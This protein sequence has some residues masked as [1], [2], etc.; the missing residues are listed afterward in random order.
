ML[1]Q[2]L[3]NIPSSCAGF[4]VPR[5]DRFQGE[6]I[7][8][9]EERLAH[10]TGFTG[11]AGL[12]IVTHDTP[13]LFVDGRYTLQ[14]L[15]QVKGM[16][17]QPLMQ[18]DI[19]S[20]LEKLGQPVGF[21]PWLTTVGTYQKWQ[22]YLLP[23]NNNP[24]DSIWKRDKNPTWQIE[25]Y[26]LKY[27]GAS[28]QEKLEK[29]FPNKNDAYLICD[30]ATLSWLCNIRGHVVPFTPFVLGW[31]VVWQGQ[32]HVF[33][34]GVYNGDSVNIR[35]E[36]ECVD[37]LKSIS[38]DATIFYDPGQTPYAFIMESPHTKPLK[39]PFMLA[40]ACKNKTEQEL[41]NS[42]H[43]KDSVAVVEFLSCLND[44]L[45][46]QQVI[47]EKQAATMLLEERKKQKDFCYPSFETIS[48]A[49]KNGA[50]IHY[51]P[52][53]DVP[54]HGLYLVDSGGQYL[55]ATTDI[56]RTIAIDKPTTE[57]KQNYTLVLKGHIALARAKFPN[58]TTGHQLD[59]LARQYL[60]QHN[61][62]YAHGTGHGVGSFLSV[63]E[64]P[65]GISGRANAVALELGMILSN[66]PGFYKEGEYGIRLENLMIVVEAG[67]FYC[68]ETLT[69]VPFDERLIDSDILTQEEKVWLLNYYQVINNSIKPHLS[70]KAV[71]WFNLR[72]KALQL[73]LN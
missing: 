23:L 62:D 51:R 37:F 66:E 4:W 55:G 27:A 17:I 61:L 10:I 57:H 52:E 72:H 47:T 22:N 65:Q 48:G 70:D 59:V 12:A 67:D 32:V 63:H 11:S 46:Q 26:P 13:T 9:S 60:W 7:P 68:F 45:S 29:T 14:A 39:N 41:A 44:G 24:I 58:G 18:Q 16:N 6:Y 30:P 38:S 40:K 69:K 54:L 20:F 64:G 50:I 73:L 15:N 25:D 8:E 49:G 43:V 56:T 33:S 42:C 21:D 34:D 71:D 19:H 2:L 28:T 31:A 3:E 1:K 36:S 5:E 35:P 53:G